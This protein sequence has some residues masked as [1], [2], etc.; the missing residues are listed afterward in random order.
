MWDL[1]TRKTC[2]ILISHPKMMNIF[3]FLVIRSS[4]KLHLTETHKHKFEIDLQYCVILTKY[5]FKSFAIFVINAIC[6]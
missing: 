4:M 6:N 2:G 1:K 5:L 3:Y